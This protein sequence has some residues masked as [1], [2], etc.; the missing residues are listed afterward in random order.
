[1]NFSKMT[2]FWA[3]K[4]VVTL[5]FPEDPCK[6]LVSMEKSPKS[7]KSEGFLDTCEALF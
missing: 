7:R 3:E 1:M 5:L 4:Q 6:G 2:R